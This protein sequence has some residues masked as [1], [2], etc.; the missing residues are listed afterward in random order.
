M[1]FSYSKNYEKDTEHYHKFRL[2]DIFLEKLARN[3]PDEFSK[4]LYTSEKFMA[5][6]VGKN[7][8]IYNPSP[9]MPEY[10]EQQIK[11]ELKRLYPPKMNYEQ[12]EQ[13][14]LDY[15]DYTNPHSVDTD[16]VHFV[17]YC[18]IAPKGTRSQIVLNFYEKIIDEKNSNKKILQDNNMFSDDM[19]LYLV[20]LMKGA[21]WAEPLENYS[22]ELLW[23][24]S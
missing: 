21:Y 2:L 1:R 16:P 24:K 17:S 20:Y 6:G 18:V 5:I 7:D 13:A 14:K 10:I 23:V 8:I 12:A 22:P 3:N 9:E 4:D 15:W 11:K 19:K